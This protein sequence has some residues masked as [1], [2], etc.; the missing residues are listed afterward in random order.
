MTLVIRSIEDTELDAAVD[1]CEAGVEETTL[2]VSFDRDTARNWLWTYMQ[3]PEADI[4]V[5]DIDGDLVGGVM[6]VE[7]NEIFTKPM[8]YMAKFWVLPA[9]RRSRAARE[10]LKATIAWAEERDCSHLYV[11]ATADLHEIEQRLFINLMK[12]AGFQEKGPV[13]SKG[14]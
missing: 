6:V 7:S 4:L 9:G 5:A 11:T 10:L 13:L 12:R 3:S 14:I 8:C 1:I 2:D